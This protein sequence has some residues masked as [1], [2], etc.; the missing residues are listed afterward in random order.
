MLVQG[1]MLCIF[2][3]I[4]LYEGFI[5]QQPRTPSYGVNE[6]EEQTFQGK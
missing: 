4:I 3:I 5:N 2:D 6:I 1:S